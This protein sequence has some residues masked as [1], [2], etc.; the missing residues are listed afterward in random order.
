MITKPNKD[1]SKLNNSFWIK[2]QNFL[3]EVNK[4]EN[5]IFVVEW[6]RSEERQKE[7]RKLWL[8]QVVRSN[9]QYWL[10]IDIAFY[11]DELYPKDNTIWRNVADIAKKYNI[12]WGYDLWKWDKPHFQDNWLPLMQTEKSKYSDIMTS[13]L[14]ESN[15]TP[16]FSSHEWDKALTEK[17]VKELIEIA[18]ARYSKRK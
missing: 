15:F 4:E 9:H 12:D 10:A 11:W 17:E 7:L 13:V 1:L 3:D 2:V 5:V 14:K 16:L 6:W 8:S 18:F